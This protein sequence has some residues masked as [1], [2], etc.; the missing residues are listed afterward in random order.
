MEEVKPNPANP[1]IGKSNDSPTAVGFDVDVNGETIAYFS[2]EIGLEE[3]IP[4]YSGGLGMLAGDT[5]R[6]AA[7][8]DLPMVAVSLLYRQ[9]YFRQRLSAD[10]TQTEEPFAWSPAVRLQETTG[11]GERRDRG[12]R[13][14][15][16]R[17]ALRGHGHQQPCG[18]GLPARYGPRGK[19]RR[20]S[21]ADRPP[22]RGRCALPSMPGSDPRHR[23]G[24]HAARAGLQEHPSLSHER[25]ARQPADGGTRQR[26]RREGRHTRHF[27]RGCRAGEALVRIHDPHA[28]G[29]W[30]RQV[31]TAA[32][33]ARHHR[34]RSRF[35][36]A[37]D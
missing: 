15:S 9:G 29:R 6:S 35:R 37:G 30:P 8:L 16:A 26:V 1:Q 24:A 27:P 14:A 7:D 13:G 33:C 23:R 25:R 2:M 10:G 5:I 22:L 18:A 28:G 21:P 4:T 11:A 34:L 36:Q 31:P 32:P 12:T 3:G 20:R 17:L 19:R